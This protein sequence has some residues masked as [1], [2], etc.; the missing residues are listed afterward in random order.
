[1]SQSSGDGFASISRVTGLKSAVCA[2]KGGA[3]M[4]ASAAANKEALTM[5]ASLWYLLSLRPYGRASQ[6]GL[7]SS[8]RT[9]TTGEHNRQTRAEREAAAAACAARRQQADTQDAQGIPHRPSR[10]CA[11]SRQSDRLGAGSSRGGRAALRGALHGMPRRE[12]QGSRH[13]LRSAQAHRRA[14]V[15]LRQVRVGGQRPDAAVARDAQR[16]GTR[17]ALGVY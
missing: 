11:G 5:I 6:R 17:S 10:I 1:M 3:S 14:A 8:L 7:K 9:N 12:A 16:N 13:Q 2:P 15:A 4:L